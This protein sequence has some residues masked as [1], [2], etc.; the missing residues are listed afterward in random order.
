MAGKL[1]LPEE[2]YEYIL[3]VSLRE[4]PLMRRLREEN[5][6]HP[7]SNFPVPPEHA[8]FMALLIQLMGARRTIEIG[9]F[10]GYS[11]LAVAMALPPDGRVIACDVNAEYTSIARRYWKEAGVDHKI[12]LR[13]KPALET[14]REL[15]AAGERSRFDFAFIDAD[16]TNNQNYYECCLEL[17]RP[18]GL[19]MVDNVIWSGRVYDPSD[20]TADTEA[21]RAFNANLLEDSRVSLSMLPVGDGVTLALKR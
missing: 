12:D 3:S 10:T 11:T 17:M 4:T 20:Q 8:Q 14:L 2:L 7:M 19:I 6:R 1:F 9:V 15:L 16:K 13:L 18:G 5:E 21:V